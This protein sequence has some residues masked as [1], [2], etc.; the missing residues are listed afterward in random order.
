MQSSSGDFGASE[1]LRTSLH[2]GVGTHVVVGADHKSSKSVHQ[3][4]VAISAVARPEEIPNQRFQ[5]TVSKLFVR[6]GEKLLFLTGSDV[7]KIVNGIGLLESTEV[8]FVIRQARIVEN[9]H[10]YGVPVTPEMFVVGFNGVG[11]VTQTVGGDNKH[12]FS[13][14]H[15]FA[16]SWSLSS[17][18]EQD[19][20]ISYP[21]VSSV[22]RRL[23]RTLVSSSTIKMRR[24]LSN[25]SWKS[26]TATPWFDQDRHR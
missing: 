19:S 6:K 23:R 26:T 17:S 15:F 22:I 3:C 12:S 16:F 5:F 18:P 4:E 10:F 7:E 9:H 24:K 13:R 1:R 21:S 2:Q 20:Q 11:D 14:L 25:A 8:L